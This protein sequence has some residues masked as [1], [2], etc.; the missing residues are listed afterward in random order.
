MEDRNMTG[1]QNSRNPAL[2]DFDWRSFAQRIRV[3]ASEDGRA[4]AVIAAEIGITESDLSR[5]RGGQMVSVAK[6][7]AIAR[8][9]G[10]TLNSWYLPP[11]PEP[12]ISTSCSGSNVKH[13]GG[14]Q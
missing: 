6:A 1:L 10:L 12:M 14:M 7:M 8:W 4:Q 13:R 3:K 11:M 2:A 9:M 5:A